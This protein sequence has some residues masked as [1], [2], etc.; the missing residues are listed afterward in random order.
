MQYTVTELLNNHRIALSRQTII[1][2]ELEK[3]AL[4]EQ[5]II[6]G[7]IGEMTFP[8]RNLDGMPK[9]AGMGSLTEYIALN[10]RDKVSADI[11]DTVESLF[12]ALCEI[13]HFLRVYQGAMKALTED[14]RQFVRMHYDERYSFARIARS[15]TSSDSTYSVSTIKR[16]HA[17]ILEKVG[18]A[19]GIHQPMRMSG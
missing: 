11:R 18:W 1:H 9:H 15:S 8:G 19:I 16:M 3:I 4:Q 2:A 14:E 17:A 6:D 7:K 12:A 13:E 10:Y 5:Q